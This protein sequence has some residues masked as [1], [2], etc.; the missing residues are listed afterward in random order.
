MLNTTEH[1]W[2]GVRVLEAGSASETTMLP[3]QRWSPWPG[4]D[5][6][7]TWEPPELTGEESGTWLVY[8][9]GKRTQHP[10]WWA[11]WPEYEGGGVVEYALPDMS[12]D[13]LVAAVRRVEPAATIVGGRLDGLWIGIPDWH[14]PDPDRVVRRYAVPCYALHIGN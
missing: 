11:D 5:T 1:T 2:H 9:A 6:L 7:L 4:G 8:S 14:G 10:G 12:A 3:P 13:D